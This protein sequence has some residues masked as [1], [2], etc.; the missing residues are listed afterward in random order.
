MHDAIGDHGGTQPGP[1]P[2]KQHSA[3][4]VAADRL[5]GR[6]VHDVRW[7]AEGL[8]EIEPN[9][10]GSQIVRL[11]DHFPVQHD[12]R[13]ADGHRVISPVSGEL[14]HMRNHLAGSEVRPRFELAQFAA[15]E[16]AHLHVASADVDG[17]DSPGVL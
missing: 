3:A 12:S 9:P 8:A 11:G 4:L 7:A 5:H 10:A 17:E 15:A 13:I 14:V 2:E 1:E 16:D 6:I